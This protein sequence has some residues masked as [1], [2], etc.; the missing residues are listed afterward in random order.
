MQPHGVAKVK[1]MHGERGEAFQEAAER[2]PGR[3]RLPKVGAL[4]GR[5]LSVRSHAEAR[6]W[7]WR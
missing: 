6:I 7:S 5:V 3:H 1:V 4:A 2:G